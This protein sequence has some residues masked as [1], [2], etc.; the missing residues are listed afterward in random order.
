MRRFLKTRGVDLAIAVVALIALMPG[1][2]LADM[3][4]VDTPDTMVPELPGP[5]V[6]G[7]IT[8]GIIGAIVLARLRK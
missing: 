3:H 8:I 5:G 6:L 2:A 4:F 1:P 7:L